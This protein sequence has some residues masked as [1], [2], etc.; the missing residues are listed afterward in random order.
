M[1]SVFLKTLG[2]KMSFHFSNN[3][4]LVPEWAILGGNNICVIPP[5]LGSLGDQYVVQITGEGLW[6]WRKLETKSSTFDALVE[7]LRTIGFS[8]SP[9]ARGR[10]CQCLF[11]AVS[12]FKKRVSSPLHGKSDRDRI[13]QTKTYEMKVREEEFVA[14]PK[15]VIQNLVRER[16]LMEQ[17]VSELQKKTEEQAETAYSLLVDQVEMKRRLEVLN[18][19]G[20]KGKTIQEVS[21][22][23]ARRKLSDLR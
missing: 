23:Q 22:R 17:K 12:S 1:S 15:D 3:E 14:L 2:L 6:K 5:D 20:N 8:L 18:N 10:I 21:E 4:T 16:E 7:S 19:L 13:I 9:L 11:K